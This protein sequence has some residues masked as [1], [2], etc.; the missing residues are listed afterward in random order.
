MAALLYIEDDLKLAALVSRFLTF[1]GFSV[2]HLPT[3]DGALEQ[4]YYGG[5]AALLLD[6]GLPGDDGFAFCAKVRAHFH[7]QIIF[8]TARR[9]D[10]DQIEGLQLG[11]DDYLLKPVPPELLLARLQRRLSPQRP[12]VPERTE[13]PPPQAAAVPQ[14]D[15]RSRVFGPLLIKLAAR[16]AFLH[17]QS[18]QLT[19]A[20]FDILAQ[21]T[22]TP[23]QAVSRDLLFMDCLGS[24][25]DGL[26][27]TIDSRIA[28]LRKKLGDD[29]HDPVLIRTV[30]GRGYLF[31]PDGWQLLGR[32]PQ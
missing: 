26:S 5:Y 8:M 27:R 19:S 13:T 16:Q 31:V 21:L 4:L 25:Y 7:G 6:I 15:S 32:D 10:V 18:L 20:E 24:S 12:L 2:T 29:P 22:A 3:T 23:G 17:G 11:A 14:P 28:R 30:W 9:S 1:H